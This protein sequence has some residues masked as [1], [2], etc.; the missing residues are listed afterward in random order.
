[1][2]KKLIPAILVLGLIVGLVAVG[3]HVPPP[4]EAHAAT[5]HVVYAKDFLDPVFYEEVQILIQVEVEPDVWQGENEETDVGGKVSCWLDPD[6]VAE[7]WWAILV[8]WPANLQPIDE[9]PQW[10]EY[11]NEE[12]TFYFQEAE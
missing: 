5:R 10:I 3:L 2:K 1:M 9:D 12:A 4:E 8:D 11:P 6:P 7:G